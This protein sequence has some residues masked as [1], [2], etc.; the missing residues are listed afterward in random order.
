ML[1]LESQVSHIIANNL[2]KFNL[3]GLAKRTCI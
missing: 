2:A 1:R 3:E